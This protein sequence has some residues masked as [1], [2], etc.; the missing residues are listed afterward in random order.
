[1]ERVDE[2]G[3]IERHGVKPNE[4]DKKRAGGGAIPMAAAGMSSIIRE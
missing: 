2:T 4:A 3:R 1:M